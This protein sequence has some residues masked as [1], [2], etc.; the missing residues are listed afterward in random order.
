MIF[1]IYQNWCK[2][3]N[4]YDYMDFVNHLLQ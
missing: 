4:A 1:K 3:D 2:T